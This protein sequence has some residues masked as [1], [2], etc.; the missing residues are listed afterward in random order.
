MA[1]KREE[2]EEEEEEEGRSSGHERENK[3]FVAFCGRRHP[4]KPTV[5][6]FQRLVDYIYLSFPP[7]S[8]FQT[9]FSPR[10]GSHL[11]PHTLLRD[12]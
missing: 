3:E 1:K 6:S 9:K 2:E 5:G 10:N 4:Q 7:P 8:S 12:Q 11:P